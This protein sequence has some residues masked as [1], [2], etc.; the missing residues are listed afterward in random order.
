MIITRN[1]LQDW[2]D[3]SQIK[4]ED[5][6]K[7]LNSIGLEVDSY[8]KISVPEKI[9]VGY[10]KSRVKHENSDHLSVC[11]VDIGEETLQIVCGAKNVAAGQFV[12]VSLIGAT[13]PSG[14]VIKPAKLRGVDSQ[15]M[16][17]SSSELGLPKM[18]E[19]IMVLDNSIGELVLGKGLAEYSAFNDEIIEIDI[20]PNRGDCLSIYGVA[21]DLGAAFDMPLK[22]KGEYEDAEGLLGIGR[23]VS[24]HADE[25]VSASLMYRAFDLKEALNIDLLR[26]IRL[27][28]AGI[29]GT[30]AMDSLL[31]YITHATGVLL[32]AY[33]Y[34]KICPVCDRVTLDVKEEENGNYGVYYEDRQ[35]SYLGISQNKDTK[36]SDETKTIIVEANYTNAAIIANAM[37]ENKNLKGDEHI[38]KSSRGSEPNL[39]LGLDLLFRILSKDS[40]VKLYAGSQQI[41]PLYEP[42][43]VS[44]S[45]ADINA[46]VG[47]EIP[48]NEIVKILKRLC[49]DVSVENEFISVK[50]PKFRHDIVNSHDICEEIVRIVGIDNIKAKPME[51]SDKNRLNST[52]FNYNNAK[53]I[54]Q[55]AAISGF[56]ECVHYVFDSRENLEDLRLSPCKVRLLNPISGELSELRRSLVGHLLDSCE[57]NT[58]NSQKAIKLFEFGKVFDEEGVE[59]DRFGFLASGL[60]GEASVLNSAKPQSVDFIYFA[61]L[62]QNII[63]KFTCKIPSENI[64]YLNEFEQAII[65]QDGIEV[66][67]IGSLDIGLADK[68]DIDKTYVCEVDFSKLKFARILV[69]GYSKFPSTS[70][71]LSLLIDKDMRFERIKSCIDSLNLAILKDFA[72]IDLYNDKNL[73]DKTSLTIR[74]NFQDMEKTL[75][76]SEVDGVMDEILSSLKDKLEI[77]LR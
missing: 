16:I 19:G 15:G 23:L 11:E 38:Y 69:D 56:Y 68:R 67:Y 61:N 20:T 4:T 48:R 25:G 32:R 54:R 73:N 13:L 46:I 14:L 39:R 72:P 76:D 5:I 41:L 9:V 27:S 26:S 55:K 71:D 59:S 52:F 65:V 8:T 34:H 45:N 29:F 70:R 64:G 21:R 7:T 17:C 24:V 3:I 62:I 37:G 42:L 12:A 51:Y 53:K 36:V 1:W 40:K 6:L 49:F 35:L 66:G 63:G 74:F 28:S 77:G 50:V 22:E 43:M 57:R 10:V 2:I 31:G 44:F 47:E 75:E 58:K 18:N 30:H 60:K 33:D